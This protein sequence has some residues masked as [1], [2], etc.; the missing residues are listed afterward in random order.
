MAS[1]VLGTSSEGA[2]RDGATT[3]RV[4][5]KVMDVPKMGKIQQKTKD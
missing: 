1:L 4:A 3:F 5:N 2:F